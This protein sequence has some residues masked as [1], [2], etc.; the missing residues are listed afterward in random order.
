MA[1]GVVTAVHVTPHISRLQN[2][3]SCVEHW[4]HLTGLLKVRANIRV[5]H[6]LF[7]V[8]FYVCMY[9]YI[10]LSHFFLYFTHAFP[11]THIKIIIKY[12]LKK[13]R[14]TRIVK[15]NIFDKNIYIFYSKKTKTY[16]HTPT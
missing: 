3:I 16:F 12:G 7:F 14:N 6:K 4:N 13:Y 10:Y 5:S 2:D 9:V 15:N 11:R 8:L 1:R